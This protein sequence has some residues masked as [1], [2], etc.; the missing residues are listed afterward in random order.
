MQPKPFR[1]RQTAF[2]AIVLVGLF[3]YTTYIR[4]PPLPSDPAWRGN[5]MGTVYTIRLTGSPLTHDELVTLRDEIDQDLAEINRQMST[6]MADSE[7]TAFNQHP[8]GE[9]FPVSPLFATLV[10]RA[11][12]LSEQTGGA[13]DPTLAPLIEAWGF[14]AALAPNGHFPDP[15]TLAATRARVGW[16]KLSVDA[17]NRLVKETD[18]VQLDLSA[19]AKG[20]AVDEVA[21]RIEQTGCTNFFVE[22]GGEVVVR[23]ENPDGVPW[24]I[25]IEAPVANSLQG[26]HLHGRVNLTTGAMATSGDYRNFRKL[27]D[28][29]MGSH[30]LDPRTGRPVVRRLTS[31]SVIAPDCAT[32]D[33]VATALIVMG[34]TEGV[35]WTERQDDL[36][37]LFVTRD[38]DGSLRD[39]VTSGLVAA[40]RYERLEPDPT[41]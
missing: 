29:S 10:R 34:P 16:E 25:G 26:E 40:T 12:V 24:R 2:V 13:F 19:L 4:K 23:G 14:G 39:T 32:A 35:A 17:E 7:I 27:A 38:A 18:G 28:G 6:Y 11:L 9:P 30:I 36:E 1:P 33:A 31:V 15:T 3:V 37:A 41:D 20:A 8:A 21:R 5:T 22:I